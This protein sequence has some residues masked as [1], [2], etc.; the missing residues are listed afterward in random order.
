VSVR[1]YVYI[2]WFRSLALHLQLF[3][4]EIENLSNIILLI[5]QLV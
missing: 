3:Y 2:F 5:N 4:L 1:Y